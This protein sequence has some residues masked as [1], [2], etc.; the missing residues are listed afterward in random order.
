MDL[1]TSKDLPIEGYTDVSS[2]LSKMSMDFGA[3][4]MRIVDK[5]MKDNGPG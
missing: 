4:F 2:K 1:L 3:I 5:Y